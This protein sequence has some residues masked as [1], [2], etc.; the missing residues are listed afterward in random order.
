MGKSSRVDGRKA[1]AA[2]LAAENKKAERRTTLLWRI[3]LGVLVVALIV[4]VGFAVKASRPAVTSAEDLRS[5]VTTYTNLGRTHT[6]KPVDYKQ[7]P[8]VGGDHNP[9]WQNCGAYD[10]PVAEENGVHSL[11][12]GAV[13]LTYDPNL[14]SDQVAKLTALV[15]TNSYLLVTPFPGLKSPVVLSAWGVQLAVDSVDSPDI[16]SFIKAYK[17]GPQ[18]PEPGSSCTGGTG[19]PTVKAAGS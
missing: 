2:A 5:R 10:K 6:T 16:P 7:V 14:P 4:G 11:E 18:T 9:V 1:K 13:W 12:H 3:G 15:A 19:T 8:P 17:Q